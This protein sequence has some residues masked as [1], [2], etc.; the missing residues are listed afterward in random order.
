MVV[1]LLSEVV[2]AAVELLSEAVVDEVLSAFVDAVLEA[3]VSV[4]AVSLDAL[5][6]EVLSAVVALLLVDEAAVFSATL[7]AVELVDDVLSL[8]AVVASAKTGCA[9]C[10]AVVTPNVTVA[11][12]AMSHVL[13]A[14]YSL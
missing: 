6:D 4:V 14:L 1:E 5:L 13:P 2:V 8:L 9:V 10:T 11:I 7:D 12:P 3:S